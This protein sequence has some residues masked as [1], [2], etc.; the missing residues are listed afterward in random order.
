MHYAFF[1]AQLGTPPNSGVR[2][3]GGE[4]AKRCVAG[5]KWAKCGKGRGSNLGEGKNSN[6]GGGGKSK[7][8]KVEK[9][10]CLFVNW[11]VMQM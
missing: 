7:T 6:L 10:V 3:S 4:A 11:A 9:F 8:K 1:R 2:C 5:E